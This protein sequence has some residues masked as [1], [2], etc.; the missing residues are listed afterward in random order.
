M[1][2][3]LLI[4]GMIDLD[5]QGHLT[6]KLSILIQIGLVQWITDYGWW[7]LTLI[8]KVKRHLEGLIWGGV[9]FTFLTQMS[10]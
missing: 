5:I 1:S 10:F 6:L 8:F 3:S 2:Q 7:N 9:F 4:V